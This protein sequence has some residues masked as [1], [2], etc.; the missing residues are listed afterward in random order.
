M[1]VSKENRRLGSADTYSLRNGTLVVQIFREAA[2]NI[3]LLINGQA[4]DGGLNDITN[5]RLVDGNEAVVVHESEETHDELAVHTVSNTTVAGDRLAK[6]LDLER[7][8][9]TRGKEST[10]RSDERGESSKGQDVELHGRNVDGLVDA[11]HC[12]GVRLGDENGVG[13][14]L[15]A[16]QNVGTEVID[17]ADEV[18]VLH[19][20][21]GH[22]VTEDDGADP[23]TE[24]TLNSLLR[25]QLDQL[26]ATKRDT[27]DVGEN[28]VGD[29]QRC[30]KEEPN[31][32]L[33]DVVHHKVSLNHNQVQSHM[34][35]SELGKLESVVTLLQRSNEEHKTCRL[36]VSV[37]VRNTSTE[38]H[39]PYP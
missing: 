32:A 2:D 39:E 25:R 6:V 9:Q 33:E 30:G 8:L 12:Q 10:E 35:P 37:R 26:C 20:Q 29:D 3:E 19:Q 38:V 4:V 23:G 36:S 27:A 16:G 24:E 22:E 5:A 28:V 18:L 11:Q 1:R 31:Q 34:G 7:A 17:R 15:Q 13:H 21:V 14:T